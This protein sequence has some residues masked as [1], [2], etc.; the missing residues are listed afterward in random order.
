MKSITHYRSSEAAIMNG[1]VGYETKDNSTIK[2]NPFTFLK[3]IYK[4]KENTVTAMP[5][6]YGCKPDNEE[7][8]AFITD[9]EHPS[10]AVI[11]FTSRHSAIIARQCLGTY[12]LLYYIC[13]YVLDHLLDFNKQKP[14]TTVLLFS[15]DGGAINSWK[16]VDDIPIYP[17][18]D[19]PQLMCFCRGCW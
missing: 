1:T 7:A 19:A 6:H 12:T 15:A 8:T 5:K 10:Y 17:L 11:T 2:L 18:A 13:A 3:R 9:T 4:G 16:K 14:L